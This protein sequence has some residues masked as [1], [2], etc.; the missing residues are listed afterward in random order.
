VKAREHRAIGDTATGGAHVNLGSESA[1]E[2]FVLRYGDV[3]ALSGDFFLPD[4]SP[5]LDQDNTDPS[6]EAL[7]SGGLFTLATIPGDKATRLGTRDELICALKVMAEDEASTDPRFAPGGAFADFM[8]GSSALLTGVEKR[9]R[10]RFLTL[11]ATNTD[12]FVAP[13]GDDTAARRDGLRVGRYDSAV[14]AYRSLHQV[15]IDKACR[16]GREGGDVSEAMAREAAAQHF[17]TDA[18]AAGHLRTPVAAIRGFWQ[19]KHPCFWERLRRKVASDTASALKELGGPLRLLPASLLYSR[20]LLAVKR[21]TA[22]YP[23]ISLG[24]LL[25]KVFHDWDN[26]HGLRLEAGG[27]LF[28]D[29][30]LEQGVT[31]RL[32]LAAVRAGIDDI[33]AA[34][35]LGTLGRRLSGQQLYQAVRTATGAPGDVFLAETKIPKPSADNPPQNWHAGDVEALWASPIVGSTG[36]TVGQAVAEVLEAGQELPRRL[37]C[38]GHGIVDELGLPAL[39]GL[40][41]WASRKACEAY[42]HG[43]MTKLAADPKD[44]VLDIINSTDFLVDFRITRRTREVDKST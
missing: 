23:V 7:I 40:R 14:L 11:G 32:V 4:N 10:D 1:D 15:A 27:V 2:R 30:C 5:V 13:D 34:F 16:L 17:L 12:H 41:Q 42:H 44:T 37:D 6:P 35:Y 29:G 19:M 26:S 39:P 20:T 38:L 31:K 22:G 33:E 43:F 3:V 21:R 18:F 8:S 25:A 28:G 24:D 9:V 36:T